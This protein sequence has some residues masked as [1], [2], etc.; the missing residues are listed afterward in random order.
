MRLLRPN[1]TDGVL[2]AVQEGAVEQT[3][4]LD[5][6]TPGDIE[7]TTWNGL[8]IVNEIDRV[9]I[10]NGDGVRIARGVRNIALPEPVTV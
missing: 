9:D 1:V 6:G 4:P 10:R 2:I 8:V 7:V 5:A 3:Q